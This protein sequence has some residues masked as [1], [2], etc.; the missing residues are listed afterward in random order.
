[1]LLLSFGP[2]FA[3]D[4]P[5]HAAAAG[6]FQRKRACGKKIQMLKPE[7]LAALCDGVI[8]I[9]ITLLVLGLEVPSVDEVPESELGSYLQKM[10]HPLLGYVVSFGLVGT[11]WSQHYQIFHFV[12]RVDRPF[13]LLNGA[14]LLLVSFIPFP[15]GLQAEYRQ[16]ELAMLLYA[17]TQLLCGL[18]LLALWQYATRPSRSITDPLPAQVVRHVHRRLLYC[19]V[20]ATLALIT[21]WIH[22]D[23]A[24]LCLVAIPLSLSATPNARLDEDS[25]GTVDG[26]PSP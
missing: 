8:A 13:L 10:L 17:G 21:T 26:S 9:A 5:S 24:R 11:Y 23:V 3:F 14:F 25:A 16:S 1:M 22:P 15:T 4:L 12:K 18:S 2:P 19:P 20:F 7:R 6:V